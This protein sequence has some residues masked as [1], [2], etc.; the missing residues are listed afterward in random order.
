MFGKKYLNPININI[1]GDPSSA[2]FF[3]ALTLMN[4]NSSLKIKNVGLNPTRTGFY[5]ILKK[6]KVNLKFINLKKK[7]NEIR[8]DIIVKSSKL[9]PMK[10][11]GF[12]LPSNN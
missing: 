4:H 6:Q 3:T 1:G 10:T 9:K 7:N 11:E 5:D 2:A 12:Y 8:G